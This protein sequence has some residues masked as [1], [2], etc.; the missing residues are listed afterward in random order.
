MKNLIIIL[1]LFSISSCGIDEDV[2]GTSVGGS[3]CP[4]TSSCGCSGH[5]KSDCQRDI[6][7]KWVVGKGC[8]CR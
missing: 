1:F 4:T 2:G 8:N 5:N 7:C 3:S 6:C